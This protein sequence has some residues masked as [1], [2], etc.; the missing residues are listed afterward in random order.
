M[1]RVPVL[2]AQALMTHLKANP[3]ALPVHLS[4]VL[5]SDDMNLHVKNA[6]NAI[7]IEKNALKDI[8]S[9]PKESEMVAAIGRKMDVILTGSESENTLVRPLHVVLSRKLIAA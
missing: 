1:T 9:D 4:V 2:G 3:E 8:E 5:R 6:K 7:E